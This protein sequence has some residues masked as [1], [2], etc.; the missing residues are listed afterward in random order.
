MKIYKIKVNGK[1]Y[2]VELEAMEEVASE[3]PKAEAKKAE[4]PKAA[5]APSGEGNKVLSPIQGTVISVDVKV[6]DKVKKGQKVCV[7]EA[8]KLEN[9]VVST[10]DGEV[11][12]VLISKGTN[13]TAKAPLIVVK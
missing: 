11:S 1:T 7:I 4:A 2:K 13:V 5:A 6:G 8:M 3:A 9:D 10:F 12:E